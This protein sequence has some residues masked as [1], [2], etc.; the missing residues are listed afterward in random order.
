[1]EKFKITIKNIPSKDV[2]SKY[3]AVAS[4]CCSVGTKNEFPKVT[5]FFNEKDHLDIFSSIVGNLSVFE[6]SNG[7]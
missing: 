4:E 1:M 5:F 7:K 6:K 2:L 3:F